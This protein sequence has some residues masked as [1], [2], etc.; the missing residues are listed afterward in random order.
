MSGYSCLQ[1]IQTPAVEG[2]LLYIESRVAGLLSK[3]P[4][5]PTERSVGGSVPASDEFYT[6]RLRLPNGGAPPPRSES[7]HISS[8]STTGTNPG[9]PKMGVRARVADWPPRKDG[10]GGGVWH[11]TVETDSPSSTN[12]TSSSGSGSG[13]RE[14]LGGGGGGGGGGVEVVV[15]VVVAVEEGCQP[16]QPTAICQPSWAT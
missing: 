11:I 3:A 4:N 13:D 8:S 7:A 16:S 2:E 6:R 12:T 10:G 15:V 5:V 14:R 1:G 9:V